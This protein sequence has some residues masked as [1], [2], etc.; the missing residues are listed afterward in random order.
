MYMSCRM[1]TQ[2]NVLGKC[3]S[4]VTNRIGLC[5]GRENPQGSMFQ[6]WQTAKAR[7]S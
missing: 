1:G 4:D 5:F 2:A 7:Q 6:T 3:I